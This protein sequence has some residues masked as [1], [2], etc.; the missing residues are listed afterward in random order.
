MSKYNIKIKN[1]KPAKILNFKI[2]EFKDKPLPVVEIFGNT[3]QGEGPRLRPAIFIR[4]GLCNFVCPGFQCTR[5]APDGEELVG[6]DSLHATSKKFKDQWDYYTDFNDIVERVSPLIF[7]N[8]DIRQ[9]III[10]GGE[11]TLHWN[12][13]TFQDL[14]E[15][16]ISRGHHVTIE[17]NGSRMVEFTREYQR[18]VMFSLSVKLSVSGEP[19]KKRIN[20]PA[21]REIFDNTEGSYLKFVVSEKNWATTEA[22]IFQI[23]HK[24]PTWVDVFLMPLGETRAKQMQETRFV[25]EK[26]A[27]LGFSFSPRIHILAFDDMDGI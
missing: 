13:K 23:L 1:P 25:F 11:P 15:Y 3:L 17:S 8:T 26:C 9:D 14:L 18:K 7:K 16:F 27:D 6:C 20:I 2:E 22:E 5:I 21:L 10:T 19:E 24:L 12:N 4:L